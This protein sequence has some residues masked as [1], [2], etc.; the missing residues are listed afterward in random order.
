MTLFLAAPDPQS[1][2]VQ[3]WV[4]LATLFAGNGAVVGIL[5]TGLLNRRKT[6]AEA[7]KTGAEATEALVRTSLALLQP[8]T[9]GMASFSAEAVRLREENLRL[10]TQQEE[11]AAE[12]ARL[13]AQQVAIEAKNRQLEG[14]IEVLE[15]KLGMLI[16]GVGGT[17]RSS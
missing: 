6:R 16:R 2:G 7:G 13:R 3:S 8:Y 4:L 11:V 15:A 9:E 14:M 1:W 12:N 5:V 10:K 17:E